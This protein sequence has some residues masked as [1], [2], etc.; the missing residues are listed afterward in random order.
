MDKTFR[1]GFFLGF[2]IAATISAI[3]IALT[4]PPTQPINYTQY[5]AHSR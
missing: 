2:A 1:N 5:Q 4:T 3:S